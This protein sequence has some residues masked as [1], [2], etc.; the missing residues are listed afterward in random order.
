VREPTAYRYWHKSGWEQ[1]AAAVVAA[2]SGATVSCNDD[3]SEDA[4][5][6]LA[7]RWPDGR[8][9]AMEVTL[10]TDQLL[11]ATWA[12]I[13]R[14]QAIFP[15]TLARHTWTVFLD[16]A[17]KLRPTRARVDHHLA[18]IEAEGLP[19]F[20]PEHRS[21]SPAVRELWEDLWIGRGFIYDRR[22]SATGGPVIALMPPR[23]PEPSPTTVQEEVERQ[24]NQLDNIQKLQRSGK[25]ER[26][27]FI[28]IDVLHPGWRALAGPLPAVAPTLPDAITT[29]WVATED[30]DDKG[31]KWWW[32]VWR[33]D[34]T[35]W[36]DLGAMPSPAPPKPI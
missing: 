6:D 13:N 10:S 22:R 23:P 4:M 29:V 17:T 24:A 14:Q 8:E 20:G 36:Q 18:R 11:K 12:G 7:L 28:W 27:L 35:G 31:E 21:A 2:M 19:R 1:R 32:A 5:F 16:R 9:A 25:A 15:A 33:A 3:G 34:R 30:L 26:H